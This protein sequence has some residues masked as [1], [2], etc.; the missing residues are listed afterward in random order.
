MTRKMAQF[1][2][3]NWIF[4]DFQSCNP[5][6]GTEWLKSSKIITD[7]K[8][9]ITIPKQTYPCFSH[10]IL[11]GIKTQCIHWRELKILALKQNQFKINLNLPSVDFGVVL[12]DSTLLNDLIIRKEAHR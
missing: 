4:P 7:G 6:I 9:T 10:T 1:H 8:F 5:E 12:I 3:F 2:D 11:Q